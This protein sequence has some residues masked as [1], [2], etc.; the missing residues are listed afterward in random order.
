M[1]S[2]TRR[3]LLPLGLYLR[4][5]VFLKKDFGVDELVDLFDLQAEIFFESGG[6]V[7]NRFVGRIVPVFGLRVI[8]EL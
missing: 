3:T 6:C 5:R 4:K 2:G 8:S 7:D 1:S